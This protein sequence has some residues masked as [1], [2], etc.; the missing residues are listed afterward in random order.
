VSSFT[1]ASGLQQSLRVDDGMLYGVSTAL[2]DQY[3]AP[4]AGCPG[5]ALEGGLVFGIVHV[6]IPGNEPDDSTIVLT[7]TAELEDPVTGDALDL[8]ACYLDPTTGLWSPDAA[9]TGETGWYLI[10]GVEEGRSILMIEFQISDELFD[11]AWYDI[12]MPPDGLVP[13]FPTY[14]EFPTF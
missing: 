14:V 9:L 12:W 13:R 4:F 6:Y 7:A 11:R 3:L 2:R 5:L 8:D 10:G 1:G